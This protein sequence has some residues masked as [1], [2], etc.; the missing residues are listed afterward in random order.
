M[1]RTA[2]LLIAALLALALAACGD[3]GTNGKTETGG[4]SL[5]A[6]TTRAAETAETA[7]NTEKTE[8]SETEQAYLDKNGNIIFRAFTELTGEEFVAL[9]EKQ[10]Y[11]P[12][13]NEYVMSGFADEGL[14]R[15]FQKNFYADYIQVYNSTED[16]RTGEDIRSADKGDLAKMA[17]GM[18]VKGEYQ[19][20]MEAISDVFD[21]FDVV[22]EWKN[23]DAERSI[24]AVI[25][26]DAAGTEYL[27]L[28]T[29]EFYTNSSAVV[30]FISRTNE[31]FAANPLNGADT[32]EA[33]WSQ[34]YGK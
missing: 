4:E 25:V 16:Y 18:N 17:V 32:V 9:A 8:L 26:K 27:V 19:D 10:G 14:S 6:D 30:S 1:K 2:V 29:T 34:S 7:E 31:Y 13:E 22:D 12:Y 3:Y 15:G 24:G 21:G 23:P 28:Y 33:V 20:G 5:K 11:E